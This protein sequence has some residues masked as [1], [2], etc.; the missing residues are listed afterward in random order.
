MKPHGPS[1]QDWWD[2]RQPSLARLSMVSELSC[3]PRHNEDPL[4]AAYIF[5]MQAGRQEKQRT[6][7]QRSERPLSEKC[8]DE[9]ISQE[10]LGHDLNTIWQFD[11]L[12]QQTPRSSDGSNSLPCTICKVL[13][14]T[15][16]GHP[17]Q[18][19]NTCY[20]NKTRGGREN[21]EK[22]GNEGNPSSPSS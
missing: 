1:I 19:I 17:P 5:D 10:S 11:N 2:V 13:C 3:I 22:R 20:L 7:M 6:T 9:T 12:T 8:K 21:G 18:P 14:R 4:P 16:L 15:D